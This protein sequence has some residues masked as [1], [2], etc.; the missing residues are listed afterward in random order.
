[1]SYKKSLATST[2][3]TVVDVIQCTFSDFVKFDLW[4]CSIDFSGREDV[5]LQGIFTNLSGINNLQQSQEPL[6]QCS[7]MYPKSDDS[8]AFCLFVY[9][10]VSLSGE[11]SENMD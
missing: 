2:G 8:F 1:M 11:F 7:A 3:I 9:V 4:D 6:R 5:Q 10:V